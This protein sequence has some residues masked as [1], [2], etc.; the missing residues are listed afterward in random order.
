[1]TPYSG[2]DHISS[3]FTTVLKFAVISR[4]QNVCELGT[5]G[6]NIRKRTTD[7]NST[8]GW[9]TG[10]ILKAMRPS[11]RTNHT[12]CHPAHNTTRQCQK[13]QGEN[14]NKETKCSIKQLTFKTKQKI[15][16]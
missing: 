14:D 2:I 8:G 1:M 7:V 15:V 12:D 13:K 3:P 16:T 10:L 6:T 9:T 11:T 4:I 5:I